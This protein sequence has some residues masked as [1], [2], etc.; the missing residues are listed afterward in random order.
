MKTWQMIKEIIE[1]PKKK[2]R[3]VNGI[4]GYVEFKNNQLV[5]NGQ[6][7]FG[8]V[9][10]VT[11]TDENEWEEVKEP[12]DFITAIKSGKCVGVEYSGA[13]YEEMSL[14]NLFYELQQDYSDKII[15]QMIL[16]GK[17]YIED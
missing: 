14:P 9:M 10:I 5:W 4:D 16:N 3:P 15:R 8:Q 12:V 11:E 2:Y 17:W 7:Q 1:N 13:K 6:G